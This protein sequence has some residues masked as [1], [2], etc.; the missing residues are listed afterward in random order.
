MLGLERLPCGGRNADPG[1]WRQAG[2]HYGH[3]GP[4]S[5]RGVESPRSLSVGLH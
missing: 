1:E 3:G 2:F 5:V 4:V